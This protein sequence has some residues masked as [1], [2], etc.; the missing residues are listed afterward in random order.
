MTAGQWALNVALNANPV[1][2]VVAGIGLLIGAFVIAYKNL[3]V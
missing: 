2:L 3:K 1:G